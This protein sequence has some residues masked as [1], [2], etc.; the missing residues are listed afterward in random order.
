MPSQQ[1]LE[2]ARELS[3]L[4]GL[5]SVQVLGLPLAQ[6]PLLLSVS[7]RAGVTLSQTRDDAPDSAI[8]TLRFA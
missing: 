2:S 4:S 7:L 8:A 5:P 1:V 6:N 3:L